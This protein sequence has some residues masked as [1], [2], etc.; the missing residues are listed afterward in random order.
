MIDNS[1]EFLRLFEKS[2]N[3][4]LEKMAQSV[5][6][7]AEANAKVDTGNLRRSHDYKVKESEHI[8][9]VGNTAPYAEAVEFK[10]ESKGGRPWFR[11]SFRNASAGFQKIIESTFKG[12]IK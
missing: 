10:P 11:L 1:K 8:A 2:M 5:K 3:D 6:A 9:I 4:V 7:E 12:V